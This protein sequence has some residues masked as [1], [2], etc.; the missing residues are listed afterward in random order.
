[1][2]HRAWDWTA[3]P[4]QRRLLLGRRRRRAPRQGGQDDGSWGEERR[5]ECG[6]LPPAA[7]SW[8]G[9]VAPDGRTRVRVAG[10]RPSAGTTA[11]AAW[12]PPQAVYLGLGICRK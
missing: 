2:T 5:W 7:R 6:G 1:V 4:Q 10:A 12:L 11:A 8:Q 3:H 9:G